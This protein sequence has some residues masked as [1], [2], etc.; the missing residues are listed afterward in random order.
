MISVET[1]AAIGG[2]RAPVSEGGDVLRAVR[3]AVEEHPIWRCRLLRS[4]EAGYLT[5][6]DLRLVFGQYQ[7]YSANFTRYLSALMMNCENDYFRAKLS[8]NLWEEGGAL[9]PE[10]RHAQIFRDFL[11]KGLELDLAALRYEGYTKHFVAAYLD[12][13]AHAPPPSA[14]A[15]LALGTEGIV[16]RLYRVFMHGLL[17]ASI[18][19]DA[20]RFFEI[21]VACDDEHAATLEEMV[22]S[23]AGVEGFRT[24]VEAGVR[25]A[26]DLRLEFFEELYRAIEASRLQGMM[27]RIQEKIS[28]CHTAPAS[29]Q[30]VF[31]SGE[32][33][34]GLYENHVARLRIDFGVT[35]VPFAGEV[36]DPRIVRIKPASCNE[37]HRHAHESVFYVLKGRGRLQVDE[38]SV[39]LAEGDLAF[40]PRWA[41][42]QTENVGEDELVLLAITDY[43]LTGRAF[44]GNYDSTARRRQADVGAEGARAFSEPQESA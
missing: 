8:Q 13:S 25:R 16:P 12:Y 14:C 27:A 31:R 10:Q 11:T 19:K 3:D 41:M 15:F 2:S 39:S 18:P 36:L 35:R 33:G 44:F 5:R 43:R 7:H 30:L 6:D 9:E 40:V 21:H 38:S 17:K 26:L 1:D 20:L 29:S 23:Y 32:A 4:C 37:K 24:M 22:R 28:L 34:V 42:H